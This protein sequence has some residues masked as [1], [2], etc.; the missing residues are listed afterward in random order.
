MPDL[1]Q[2]PRLVGEDAEGAVEYKWWLSPPTA[3]RLERL[4]TQMNFRVNEGEGRCTYVIGVRDDGTLAGIDRER[5]A[6]SGET[7]MLLASLVGCRAYLT[8][9][10]QLSDALWCAQWSIAKKADPDVSVSWL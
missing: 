10:R 7:L 1:L 5:L 8:S 6:R 3:E 2:G 4:A 9:L